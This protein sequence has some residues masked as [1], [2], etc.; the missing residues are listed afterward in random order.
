MHIL[1]RNRVLGGPPDAAHVV[2]QSVHIV[3]WAHP[4]QC[5]RP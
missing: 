4:G 1:R 5:W 2:E 3:H